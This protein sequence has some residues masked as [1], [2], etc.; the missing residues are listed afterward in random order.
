VKDLNIKII[1]INTDYCKVFTEKFKDYPNIEIINS[2]LQDYNGEYD[3]IVS[4]ANSFGLMDG[5][6]DYAIT[7]KFGDKLMK[8]VQQHIIRDY[9]GL[10]PIG[11]SFILC[12]DNDEHQWLAHTPTMVLPQDIRGTAIVY[13]AMK[14]TLIAIKK[15]NKDAFRENKI[16]TVLFP[17]FGGGC[18]RV[19]PESMAW[20]MKLAYEHVMDN[21]FEISWETA[22]QRF[23]EIIETI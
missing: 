15:H 3:C 6:F 2:T 17:M 11:T 14:A 19:S 8:R 9:A 18:G 5:G 1:D 13:F 21:S 7:Q 4:P 16:Y 10:Q 23:R 22:N 20:Q 12:T